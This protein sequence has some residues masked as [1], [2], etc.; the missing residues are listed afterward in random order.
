MDQFIWGEYFVYAVAFT[1]TQLPVGTGLQFTPNEIRIDSDRDF[2]FMKTMYFSDNDNADVYIKYRDDTIGRYLMKTG[3]LLRT[4]AGRGLPID[5]SGA[6]D[7]RPFIWSTGYTIRK[8]T[9]FTVE[10]SNANAI[11]TPNVYLAFHGMKLNSGIAPWKAPGLVRVPYVYTLPRSASTLPDG[12]YNVAANATA[13][14][15][16]ST[17]KDSHFVAKKITGSATGAALV[18][19]QDAGRDRAW[20]NTGVHVRNLLGSG[21]FPNVLASPRFVQRGSVIN[22]TVQDLSGASNNVVINFVGEKLFGG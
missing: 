15:S 20:M 14:I 9:T 19:I 6:Y 8:A 22:I 16:I 18:T 12:V 3:T 13:S 21:S 4:I 10:A 1:P 7:F 11:I 17:D 2:Q 5:N